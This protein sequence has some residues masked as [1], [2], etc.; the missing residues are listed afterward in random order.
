[1]HL[2]AE[3]N[4]PNH[5]I[6]YAHDPN[7]K[8]LC[9]DCQHDHETTCL[10]CQDL[11]SALKE[12]EEAFSKNSTIPA[13]TLT[14]MQYKQYKLGQHVSCDAQPTLVVHAKQCEAVESLQKGWAIKGSKKAARFTEYQRK[15]LGD[16]FRIGQETGHKADPEQVVREMQYVCN[17]RGERRFKVDEFLTAGQIQSFFSR[18]AAKLCHAATPEDDKDTDNQ[19]AEDE[20]AFLITRNTI[21][22]QYTLVHPIIYDTWNLCV[23]SSTKKLSKLTVA[24]LREICYHFN[25]EDTSSRHRKKPYLDFISE[26]VA[27][28]SCTSLG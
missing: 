5:C 21:L 17:E 4:V 20:K 14:R 3:A 15:Y 9:V 1:M 22:M 28:C 24:Q 25:M 12:I 26:L 18:T 6:T 23:V 27:A 13:L 7:D 2:T 10:Q 8:S 11:K 19:A 16:K